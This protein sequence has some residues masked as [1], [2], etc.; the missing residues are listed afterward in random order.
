M[1]TETLLQRADELYFQGKE[2]GLSDAVYDRLAEKSGHICQPKGNMWGQYRDQF[3]I[4]P[5]F[6]LQRIPYSTAQKAVCYFPKFDG[7][8]IA[9]QKPSLDT[10]WHCVTRGNGYKGKDIAILFPKT[11]FREIFT[12]WHK[13]YTAMIGTYELCYTVADGGREAL[14][15]DIAKGRLG[16]YYLLPHKGYYHNG[17]PPKDIPSDYEGFPID[18][19][20]CGLDDNQLYKYKGEV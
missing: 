15:A 4:H 11:D 5:N 17:H 13:T 9:V 3:L 1:K 7:I 6:G 19:Y 8:F 10:P 12:S 2:T 18:G 16:R 20:V 14:C